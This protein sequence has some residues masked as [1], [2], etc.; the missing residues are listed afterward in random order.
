MA[1]TVA[2]QVMTLSFNDIKD[3]M[4]AHNPTVRAN[5]D[6]IADAAQSLDDSIDL[7][8]Q[9]QT[10]FQASV[11]SLIAFFSVPGKTGIRLGAN[12]FVD[13][14][15][16]PVVNP[17]SPVIANPPTQDNIT[18]TLDYLNFNLLNLYQTQLSNINAQ[19]STLT[20][21]RDNLWKSV[22]QTD[23]GNDQLV[24]GT[25]QLFLGYKALELQLQALQDNRTQLQDQLNVM[26][27]RETLG[28]VTATDR[29]TLELQLNDLEAT[30]KSLN[31]ALTGLKGNLNLFLGQEYD[32]PL[33]VQDATP[34]DSAKLTAM[35]Y[36]LD[37]ATAKNNS[38]AARL[39]EE[40]DKRDTE[41]R[42]VRAD[43]DKAFKDVQ[44]KQ[45]DLAREKMK[46]AN[47]QVKWNQLQ[48]KYQLGI[49]SLLELN[50]GQTTLNT[51]V[52]KV[53]TA[54]SDLLK[55]YTA[56]DWLLQGLAVSTDQG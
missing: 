44:T 28:M 39:Q 34:P 33:T 43:F 10:G 21:Q 55:S 38:L 13:G 30:L 42:Q 53:K 18:A 36:D 3:E 27:V 5:L 8:N 37:L 29:R 20:T 32:S 26:K 31:D 22:L 50:S 25:Q 35:D 41:I 23:M 11:N 4:M 14:N 1:D 9:A 48:L 45:D 24:W 19:K 6:R 17:A 51:Q 15:G 12:G 46:L 2:Q 40:T 49:V 47:E 54:G 56:Y 7:L 16:N 52:R